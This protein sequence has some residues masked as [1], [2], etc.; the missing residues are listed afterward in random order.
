MVFS[1]D[2]LAVIVTCLIEKGWTC[3][4]RI[5]KEFPKH[6][7]LEVPT[8]RQNDRVMQRAGNQTFV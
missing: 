2:D 7:Q 1:K 4:T 8:N 6:F 5:A 3:S